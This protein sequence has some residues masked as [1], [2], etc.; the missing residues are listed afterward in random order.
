MKTKRKQAAR[1]ATARPMTKS[2]KAVLEQALAVAREALP[3]YGARTSRQDFTLYQHVAI[4]ALKTFLKL[5]YR[6]VQALLQDCAD[7]R[8][9][10]GLEKVPHH[11]TLC[12]AEQ[13]LL[14]K[15]GSSGCSG[16]SSTARTRAA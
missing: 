9:V 7:L 5:D 13:R 15:R 8:D 10:L 2:P 3:P 6:G 14:K 11:S 12:K 4:L 16:T 1:P